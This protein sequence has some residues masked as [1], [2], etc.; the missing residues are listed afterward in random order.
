MKYHV[1]TISVDAS[2]VYKKQI[3]CTWLYSGSCTTVYNGTGSYKHRKGPKGTEM[4]QK[5]TEPEAARAGRITGFIPTKIFQTSTRGSA[6]GPRWGASAPQTPGVR[7]YPPQSWTPPAA[8]APNRT[9]KVPK[10]TIM[11]SK[12]RFFKPVNNVDNNNCCQ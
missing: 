6:P 4:D 7:I 1:L 9:E 11:I 12:S 2:C 3:F 5:D 8:Y 10:R